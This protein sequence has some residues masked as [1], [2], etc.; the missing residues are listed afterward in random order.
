MGFRGNLASMSLADIFQ[1]LAA[2]GQSGTLDVELGGKHRYV[3]FEDG[4]VAD[5]ARE[6]SG[7]GLRP[8]AGYLAGRCL[9]TD[10]QAEYAVRRSEDA[11]G[12]LV[13]TVPDLGYASEDQVKKIVIRY[14][15][16]EIYDLFTWESGEFEFTDGAPPEAVFG[17]EAVSAGVRLPTGGLVMEAA[18]RI[19]EWGRIRKSLPSGKEVF[20]AAEDAEEG[21][22]ELD[23]VSRRVLSLADGTRDLDDL[24]SDS[25][26]SRYEVGG[27]LCSFL[28]EGLLRSAEPQDLEQA[29]AELIKRQRPDRAVKAYERLVAL[30]GDTMEIRDRL[31]T[32]AIQAEDV[33]RAVIHLGVMADRHVE[34]GHAQKAAEVWQRMLEVMPGNTRAHQGLAE[35]HRRREERKE[36][37]KHYA[38]LARAHAKSHAG[39]KAAAAARAGL[40]VDARS[41]E[42]RQ[43]LAEA[44]IEAGRKREAAEEFERLGDQL[45]G[46]HRAR[47]AADV[48]RRALQLDQSRK[49]AKSQLA[50]ILAREAARKRVKGRLLATFV[51]MVILGALVALGAAYEVLWAKPRYQR[52][53]TVYD[54]KSVLA[55]KAFEED[56]FDEAVALYREVVRTCRTAEYMLSIGRYEEKA[57][58]L[59][60]RCEQRVQ[61]IEEKRDRLL[62]EQSELIA[63]LKEDARALRAQDRLAEALKK[64]V[65][66]KEVGTEPDK[67]EAAKQ[68]EEVQKDIARINRVLGTDFV[69]DDKKFR[70]VMALVKD[71]PNDSKIRQQKVPVKV[72]SDPPGASVSLTEGVPATTPCSLQFPVVGAVR[73]TFR[74]KGYSDKTVSREAVDVPASRTVRVKLERVPAWKLRIGMAL[75]A[76]IVLVGEA[77]VFGDRGGNVW[78]L[79]AK[80]GKQIWKRQ[81]GPLGAVTGAVAVSEGT[82]FV[83]S[84]DR[85]LYALDLATGKDRWPPLKAGGLLRAA[86]RVGRVAMLNNQR[87]VFVGSDD[88]RVYCIDAK[89]GK[90]RWKSESYGAI[91]GSVLT[92]RAAI[93]AGSADGR[94]YA[95][96]PTSGKEL[97]HLKLGGSVRTSPIMT[98]DGKRMYLGADDHIAYAVDLS[99]DKGTVAWRCRAEDNVRSGPVLHG[100]RLFF[101]SSDGTVHA[102][103]CRDRSAEPIWEHKLGGTITAAPLVTAGRVYVGTHDGRFFALDRR[104]DGTPVWSYRTDGRVRSTANWV[105]G[106]VLFGSDDGFL[107][108][109]DE[110]P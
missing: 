110:R 70:E 18:R 47:A 68:I 45:L 61:K 3:R 60:R 101:G 85:R 96:D 75:E 39:E 28:E 21:N 84:L 109:F 80:D 99:P 42:L 20:I 89:T 57:A 108:A 32:T 100:D 78:A 17:P 106:L 6:Y 79:R 77:I 15:E 65:K 1:N 5:A 9:L 102:V 98:R 76:P 72:E 38:E 87:Y 24:V 56:K 69:D 36:C 73:L 51:V 22:E 93:Y 62:Q 16:E 94:L 30:G 13:R 95:L 54:Q 19:D 44:L 10:D 52:A 14:V 43:L 50:N 23:A 11:G 7:Q 8:V 88:G 37:L 81:L 26:L 104:N 58:R 67:I 97:W 105:G 55:E 64:L 4:L 34:E 86:P 82:V 107:Y 53:K 35:F 66:L 29:A 33:G 90:L 103:R 40:E 25:Y 74:R 46:D 31:A 12:N 83:P 91:Q 27:I 41:F 71:F 59:R 92:T 2:N 48:Y 63:R 49:G